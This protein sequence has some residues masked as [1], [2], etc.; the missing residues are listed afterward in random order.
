MSGR[1][2]VEN[3]GRFTEK[4]KQIYSLM[5]EMQQKSM[6]TLR[7][8]VHWDTIQLLCQ[9]ILVEGF[10]S[11]RLFKSSKD[12]I[13]RCG[14]SSVFVPHGVGHLLGMDVHDVQVNQ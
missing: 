5:L 2:P 4:S 6:K 8:G 11:L 12:E 1:M 9:Q 3:G 13:L 7:L 14:I 10:L